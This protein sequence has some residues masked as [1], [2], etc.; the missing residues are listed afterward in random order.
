MKSLKKYLALD[1]GESN[2]RTVVGSFDGK[3]LQMD[4]VHRFGNY[5]VS[6][7]NTIYWDIL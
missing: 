7:S 3:K 2:G 5:S 1:F 6:A 4:I